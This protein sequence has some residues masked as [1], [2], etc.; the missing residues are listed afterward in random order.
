MSRNGSGTASVINTFSPST[1]ISSS[2]V[3]ANFSDIAA[4]L[5]NSLALDG[6][7]SMTGQFKAASGTSS[8][9]GMGFAADTNTGL[10]RKGSDNVG[11]VAGG[12][13]IWEWTTSGIVMAS[14][15]TITG[16]DIIDTTQLKAN[17]VTL[18]KLATQA[19]GTILANIS[20]G[21]AVPSA[22]TIT[23]IIDKV[24]GTQGGIL[25]RGAASWAGLAAGTADYVL[26]TQ[27]AGANPTW[28]SA[29]SVA[30]PT[31]SGNS[32]KLLQS[33]GSSASWSG[34]SSVRARAAISSIGSSNT[35]GTGAVNVASCTVPVTGSVRVNF[36]TPLA[37]TNYQVMCN[38]ATSGGFGLCVTSITKNTDYCI[39][40]FIDLSSTA[41][42]PSA[43]DVVVYGG[44]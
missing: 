5:T 17:S 37:S 23:A 33:D 30:L 35:I 7:S 8:A 3:N 36:T 43:I 29:A 42:T 34:D 20:G 9:P 25:Y 44:Y 6:Q 16:T 19:D 41:R 40:A 26:T 39:I 2:A 24:Y 32:G 1:T 38:I 4:D 14:G 12:S 31:Q 21:A 11:A 22:A 15:K 13:D 27:G 28:K 10:Y 18:A